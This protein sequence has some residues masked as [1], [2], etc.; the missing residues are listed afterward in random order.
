MFEN[1]TF[2]ATRIFPFRF[3][4][5]STIPPLSKHVFREG[6]GSDDV[7]LCDSEIQLVT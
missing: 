7:N 5:G 1:V 4:V 6:R 3:D 2:S